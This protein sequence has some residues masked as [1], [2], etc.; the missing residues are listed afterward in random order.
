MGLEQHRP[1]IE[2]LVGQTIRLVQQE[3]PNGI[4]LS[5]TEPLDKVTTPSGIYPAFYGC[6]DWHSAV[7]SHWQIVRAMRLFPD[8][9]FVPAAVEV[10]NQHLTDKFHSV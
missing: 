8:S 10:L 7:H 5:L 4:R 3:Y 6:Y 2:K 9:V 1:L